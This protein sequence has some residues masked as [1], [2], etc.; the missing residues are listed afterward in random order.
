MQHAPQPKFNCQNLVAQQ[1]TLITQLLCLCHN[2]RLVL[3]LSILL[4]GMYA[5]EVGAWSDSGT[6]GQQA[7]TGVASFTRWEDC[8]QACDAQPA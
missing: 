2:S 3:D 6:S 8:A 7:P 4:Q 1:Y 5:V